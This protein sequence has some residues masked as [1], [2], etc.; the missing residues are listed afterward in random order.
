MARGVN[1][2]SSRQAIRQRCQRADKRGI[3]WCQMPVQT[4]V[5]VAILPPPKAHT[6]SVL[7]Y[8]LQAG[9]R[10]AFGGQ[11]GAL[12]AFTPLLQR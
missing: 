6:F 4:G 10:L 2:T 12:E 5:E 1:A 9:Q 3:E 8:R 11:F 7:G